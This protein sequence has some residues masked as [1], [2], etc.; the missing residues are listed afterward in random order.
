MNEGG[1]LL[2]ASDA[3]A[4]FGF[5]T[6]FLPTDFVVILR[7]AAVR[8]GASVRFFLTYLRRDCSRLLW[9]PT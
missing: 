1:G 5:V 4:A 8:C 3:D 9:W 7:Q 6:G 2:C